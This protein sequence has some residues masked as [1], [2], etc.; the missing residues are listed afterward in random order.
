MNRLPMIAAAVGL[1]LAAPAA[2]AQPDNGSA[3]QAQKADQH[4]AN[5]AQRQSVKQS[6]RQTTTRKVTRATERKA[7]VNAPARNPTNVRR[8]VTVRKVDVTRYRRV[9][10]A[11]RRYR[12][13]RPWIAP[14]G[15]TYR[16]FGLGERIP[17][18]LLAAS[19]FLS[20]FGAYGLQ[21][22]PYGYVWVRDGTDA[23]LVDRYTGEVIQVQ[24][25][26]FY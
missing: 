9:V 3:K 15:F 10:R 16:R 8:N 4:P 2:L 18:S 12:I 20:D 22:P 26:L 7:A 24:Y 13:T 25:G 1:I 17:T 23:V 21:S 11:P 14:R 19:F 6:V 5:K